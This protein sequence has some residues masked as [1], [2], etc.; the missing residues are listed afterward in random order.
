MEDQF[1]KRLNPMIALVSSL[2]VMI[3]LI[4]SLLVLPFSHENTNEKLAEELQPKQAIPVQVDN[5]PTIDVAVYR[6]IQQKIEHIPLEEYVIGV[7]ASEMSSTFEIEALKAQSLAART[8]IVRQLLGK[9]NPSVPEGANVTD[10]QLNQVYKNKSELRTSWGIDYDKKIK[11]IT[12]AVNATQ[13]KIITYNGQ[14]IEPSFFSTS[15]GYTEN[16]EDYWENAFPY[17]RSVV[18]PWDKKSP[19]FLDEKVITIADFEQK[20]G[21]KLPSDGSV[22]RIL[23]RTAGNRVNAIEISGK[24]FTGRD[25]RE[26]LDLRSTDFSW[27]RK[28]SDIYISTKGFGHGVGMSQYGAN[29]MAQEGKKYDEIISY[30]YQGVKISPDNSFITKLTAEK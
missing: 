2:F 6:S 8:Y 24:T 23:T 9:Q 20:L 30:Y 15:N 28:G 21:I 19:K 12:E 5:G 7:V 16:S 3:L 10:T 29:G 22:G 1:M 17:L 25:I 26:R 18:S 14:L 27:Q 13:G 4:P 11:R